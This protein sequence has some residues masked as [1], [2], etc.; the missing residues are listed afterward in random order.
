[1]ELYIDT[2]DK[3]RNKA[4]FDALFAQ[5]EQIEQK[6][7]SALNGERL[8]DK[9]ASRISL[10]RPYAITDPPDEQEQAKEWAIET[11]LRFA[12]AFQVRIKEL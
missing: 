3:E 7:G 5:R 2:E 8:D 11:M 9:R 4:A 10:L 12:D 6:I 1:M